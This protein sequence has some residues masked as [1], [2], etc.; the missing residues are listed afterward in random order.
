MADQKGGLLGSGLAALVGALGPELMKAARAV[1]ATIPDDSWLRSE[2]AARLFG[3]V[4]ELIEKQ[5]DK[6]GTVGS[7]LVAAGSDFLEFSSEE[8]YGG[9]KGKGP[10]SLAEGWINRFIQSAERRMA[11]AKSKDELDRLVPQLEAELEA[12]KKF[13]GFL[14]QTA[15]AEQ[16]AKPAKPIDWATIAVKFNAVLATS[17]AVVDTAAVKAAGPVGKLADWLESQRGGMR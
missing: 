11:A 12:R 10:Q 16:V 3:V 5:G 15:E 14:K 13:A 17:A 2:T 4:R 8:L 6:L 9:G 7:T 1:A